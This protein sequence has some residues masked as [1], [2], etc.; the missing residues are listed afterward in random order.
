MGGKYMVGQQERVLTNQRSHI[1]YLDLLRIL[2]MLAVVILHTA[3]ESWYSLDI[4]SQAWR[5]LNVWDSAVRWSVPIFIM[6]SGALFLSP[7]REIRLG[8]LYGKY[9]L[10]LVLAYLAWSGFYAL[11]YLHK[12]GD[13]Y[14]AFYQF[15]SGHAH[16][17]F[18]PMLAGLYSIVPLLRKITESRE[19]MGYFLVLSFIFSSLVPLFQFGLS[20][21]DGRGDFRLPV[22][23]SVNTVLENINFR[24]AAGYSFYFVLGYRLHTAEINR[25][26]ET[27]IYLLGAFGLTAT[28]GLTKHFSYTRNIPFG[29]FYGYL[30]FNVVLESV[31]AFVFAKNRLSALIKGEKAERVIE[32][33]SKYSFGV[34]L[35]H[36][37]FI[38]RL[39]ELGLDAMTFSPAISVAVI[40]IIVFCLSLAVSAILNRIPVVKKYLV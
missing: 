9:I 7:E 31:A 12:S 40:T 16:L 37:F 26:T 18:L 21:L 28:I 11:V 29:N 14:G 10:R 36:E 33:L 3:S 27:V 2:S 32:K 15:V 38:E 25:R 13:G 39:G 5:T 19:A 4:R 17:W 30:S 6:I 23:Q 34:Y 24:F 35:I 1:V 20:C 22:V 8:T